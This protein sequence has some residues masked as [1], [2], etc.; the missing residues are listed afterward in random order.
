V[1]GRHWPL[2]VIEGFVVFGGTLRFAWWQ[3]R[4][5][6]RDQQRVREARARAEAA[7]PEN[8]TREGDGPSA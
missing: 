8:T 6:A 2:I 3:L 4:S 1:I 7:G 5:V